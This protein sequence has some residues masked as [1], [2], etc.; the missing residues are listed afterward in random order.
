[1][2]PKPNYDWQLTI[3]QQPE[4]ARACGFGERDRRVVDP[5]PILELIVRDKTTGAVVEDA[6][7]L[8]MHCT[9]VNAD[10]QADA[11]QFEAHPDGP[12]TQRLMGTCVASAF[13]G[14][15]ERAKHGVFYVF[16]DLSCR[17]PGNFRLAFR[18]MRIDPQYMHV[19]GKAPTVA[20]ITSD[21]FEVFTAKEF[22][23][24]KPS[25]NLLKALR[26]CGLNVGVKKGRESTKAKG[27]RRN[28][29]SGDDSES[30]DEEDDESV[31]AGPSKGKGKVKRKRKRSV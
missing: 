15:D 17:T 22:P 23:G 31:K 5:P 1:M 4:A 12:T 19:G 14:K 6:A 7:I 10:T 2:A 8:A 11:S 28:D 29:D 26:K 9:L 20:R 18:L 25:S 13:P 3:R 21:R 16:P 30:E 24:M 27:G